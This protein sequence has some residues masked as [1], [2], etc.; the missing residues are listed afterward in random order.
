[1]EKEKEVD[2][3][4]LKEK[5]GKLEAQIKELKNEKN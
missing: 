1:M 2:I 3:K 5:L 4:E